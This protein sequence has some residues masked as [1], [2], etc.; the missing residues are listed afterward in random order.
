MKCLNPNDVFHLFR[1][2]NL[3]KE[4]DDE[5]KNIHHICVVQ[6]PHTDGL[7]VMTDQVAAAVLYQ[8]QS[9]QALR[10]QQ[11][12]MDLTAHI[13][14]S[15]KLSKTQISQNETLLKATGTQ[16]EQ[17]QLLLEHQNTLLK[18]TDELVEVSEKQT[19]QTEGLI[20]VSKNQLEQIA[21]LT[22]VSEGQLEV[23]KAMVVEA[24]S[25]TK[26]SEIIASLTVILALLT[27][28]LVIPVIKEIGIVQT[29]IPVVVLG[30]VAGYLF[31]RF[32]NK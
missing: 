32:P 7:G 24:R 18:L 14:A 4:S 5:L 25:T 19:E 29:L 17:S 9:N 1:S 23:A 2:G 20:N 6:R 28:Y 13:E 27:Y 10:L 16:I 26:I 30:I 11:Q 12:I 8:L 22:K 3:L 31:R 15:N 21:A